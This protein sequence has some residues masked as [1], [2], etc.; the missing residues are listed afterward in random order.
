MKGPRALRTLA[1]TASF[2]AAVAT[3]LSPTGGRRRRRLVPV[4][5]GG[6]ATATFARDVQRSGWR[7]AVTT[8]APLLAGTAGIEMIGTR[9]GVP[10]GRYTY[11]NDLQPQLGGVPVV[12]PAAWYAMALPAAHA[13]RAIT[14]H[15]PSRVAAGALAL[16][17]WDL[18]LDPQ[19]LAEGYWRWSRGGRYRGVPVSNLLGWLAV[20]SIA[21][22]WID[23]AGDDE[24]QT[25]DTVQ[26]A[27]YAVVAAMETV[28]FVGFFRDRLVGLVGGTAMGAL[29]GLAWRGHARGD[30][31]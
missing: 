18:F 24:P 17:A 8:A 25:A 20:S 9:T 21:I 29:A 3:S 27:T 11:T 7:R 28:A 12:V 30:A 31:R 2:A 4:V 10:F 1:M 26:V 13:G 16:T 5:V 14:P 23:R 15:R 22:G 6:L 19:M